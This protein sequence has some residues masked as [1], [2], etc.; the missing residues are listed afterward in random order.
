MIC[1]LKIVLKVC[2][3]DGMLQRRVN[4]TFLF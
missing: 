4:H 3:M 1:T 2:K